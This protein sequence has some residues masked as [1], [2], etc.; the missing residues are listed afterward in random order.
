ML[1]W[2]GAGRSA[3]IKKK[4]VSDVVARV[5]AQGIDAE[6]LMVVFLDVPWENWSPAGG[7]MP[8]V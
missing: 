2:L 7:R 6:N 8:H 1:H 5:S 4:V 3:R